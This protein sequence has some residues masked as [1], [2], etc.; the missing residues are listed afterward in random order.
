MHNDGESVTRRYP[1]PRSAE[2]GA[3]AGAASVLLGA[4]PPS[5][6]VHGRGSGWCSTGQR[7]AEEE[8]RAVA[9][10]MLRYLKPRPF[11]APDR[12]SKTPKPESELGALSQQAVR[13]PPGRPHSRDRARPPPRAGDAAVNATLM[14]MQLERDRQRA[15]PAQGTAAR[16]HESRV[17]DLNTNRRTQS[18]HPRWPVAAPTSDLPLPHV[19]MTPPTSSFL[20]PRGP[21]P[22]LA[23]T[24]Y[25]GPL[26]HAHLP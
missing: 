9:R 13:C 24:H 7:S 10:E 1:L 16:D 6:R 5:R 26:R 14:R 20:R 18:R 8:R 25:G 22:P 17:N 15:R 11:S 23:A 2:A 21:S 12:T 3:G 19:S 4:S